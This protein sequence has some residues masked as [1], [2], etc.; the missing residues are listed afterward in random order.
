MKTRH[1]DAIAMWQKSLQKFERYRTLLVPA[2]RFLAHRDT[3]RQAG[4]LLFA[5]CIVAMFAYCCA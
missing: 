3:L 4:K 5:V 2:Q 1:D